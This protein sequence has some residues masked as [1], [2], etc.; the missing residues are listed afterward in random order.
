MLCL[1]FPLDIP[2]LCMIQGQ[3]HSDLSIGITQYSSDK[4]A[5]S[6]KHKKQIIYIHCVNLHFQTIKLLGNEAIMWL[7][8][9]GCTC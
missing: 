9:K 1:Q 3:C 7:S 8:D 2:M 4:S 5:V 6:L